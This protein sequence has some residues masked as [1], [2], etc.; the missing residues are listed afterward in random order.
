MQQQP[1]Q[2]TMSM[3]RSLA[4]AVLAFLT[5]IGE[6]AAHAQAKPDLPTG[7]AVLDQFVEASGGQAAY[8]RL[9]NRVS[10]GTVEITG[11]NIKGTIKATQAAPNQ[12]LAV[13]DLGAVGGVVTQGTD[14][15]NAWEV[16]TLTGE[17]NLEG[18][19]KESFIRE[20]DFYKEL[21]WKDLYSKVEC[22][23]IE[24]VQGKPAYKVALTPRSGKPVTEYYDKTSHLL[25]KQATIANTPMGEVPVENYPSDYKKVDGVLIPF[26]ATQKV[27]TQQIVVKMNDIKHNVDVP[28]GTFK[29]PAVLEQPEKKKAQ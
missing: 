8:K 2:E 4:P 25:V 14:G 27:L 23:A 21:R 3:R 29:R 5:A 6:P 1:I 18:D 26:T 22:I 15:K 16:S 13:M 20:A 7:D 10:T 17:R 28:A 19:E 24:D 9:K 12:L 11:A